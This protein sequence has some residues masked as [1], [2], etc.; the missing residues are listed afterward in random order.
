MD[1]RPRRGPRA[2]GSRARSPRRPLTVPIIHVADYQPL[3]GRISQPAILACGTDEAPP[4]RRHLR[5]VPRLLLAPAR[6]RA[7][8]GRPV[9]AVQGL[10]DS[11]LSLLARAR[12]D[13]HRRRD[14]LRD[15]VVAQRPLPRLQVERRHRPRSPL[16]VRDAERAL[17]ALGM[18]V[19]AMVEDEADDAI[20]TAVVDRFGAD[21]QRR[22]GHHLLG[23]QGSR[24]SWWTAIPHRAARPDASHH[25]RRGRDRRRSSASRPPASRTTWPWSATAATAFPGFPAG[26]PRAP[27]P[28]SRA[29]ST[30]TTSRRRP[31]TGRCRCGTRRRLAATLDQQRAEALLYRPPRDPQPRC[32]HRQRRPR[33]T[34]SPGTGSRARSSS[35]CARSSASTR[36]A[37]GSIAGPTSLGVT[38]AGPARDHALMWPLVL[39]VGCGGV[40]GMR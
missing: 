33:W 36:S 9:N 23:R 24:R 10:V 32:G 25:L 16:P 29:G 28:S 7:P 3:T 8:D 17:E 22:A 31:S 39:S 40:G 5:A 26:A 19:W 6:R 13:P 35:P 18:P 14:R 11:M 34:T 4:R 37:S 38:S 2:G 30:S 20:A 27:P 12:R 1:R 15:R 21:P